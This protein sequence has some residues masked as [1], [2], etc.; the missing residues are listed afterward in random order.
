MPVTIPQT[1]Q[2]LE[3]YFQT[4]SEPTA[5]QFQELI[6]TMFYL[7]QNALNQAN[8]AAA[9]AAAAQA[10]LALAQPRAYLIAYMISVGQNNMLNFNIVKGVNIASVANP[11]FATNPTT[12]TFTNPLPD[13]N[14]GVLAY[15]AGQPLNVTKGTNSILIPVNTGPGTNGN[16]LIIYVL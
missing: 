1:Q 3:S 16:G 2:I 9:A 15:W 5:P 4:G 6:G 11:N 13:T 14:Y 7:Y 10:A 8:Q 12:V